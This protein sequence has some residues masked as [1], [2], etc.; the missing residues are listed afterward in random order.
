MKALALIAGPRK[1]QVTDHI[2]DAVLKGISEQ[3]IETE[4]I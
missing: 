1:G 2:A 3:Q 4:K